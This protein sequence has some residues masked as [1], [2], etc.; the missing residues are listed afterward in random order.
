M[1]EQ[2]VHRKLRWYAEQDWWN[3]RNGVFKPTQLTKNYKEDQEMKVA[4][5]ASLKE[6]EL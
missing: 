4:I 1:D 2:K 5:A 3:G 6:Q